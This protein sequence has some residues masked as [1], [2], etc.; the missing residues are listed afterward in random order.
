MYVSSRILSTTSAAAMP[1]GIKLVSDT[2]G[3]L[4]STYGTDLRAGIMVGGDPSV[5]G[6]TGRYESLADYQALQAT[7]MGDTEFSSALQMGSHLFGDV[8]DTIWR[9]RM[10]PGE[11]EMV[12]TI[13]SVRMNLSRV[14]EALTFAAETATTISGITGNQIGFSTA[15]TGDRCRLNWIGFGADLGELEADNDKLEASDAY[16]DLFKRSEGLFIPGDFQQNL[17][18]L[19]GPS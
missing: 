15:A 13:T 16:L 18:V 8:Q 6:V 19:A 5:I 4:N 7:L 17:W 3:Y 9:S 1:Q 10:A 12:A 14:G 11:P 2:L